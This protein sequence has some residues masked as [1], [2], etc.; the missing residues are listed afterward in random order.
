M[1]PACRLPDRESLRNDDDQTRR[2]VICDEA[3]E[4]IRHRLAIMTRT[5]PSL[6]AS[7]STWSSVSLVARWVRF[8]SMD[9]V[10]PS[11]IRSLAE[12]ANNRHQGANPVGRLLDLLSYRY[13]FVDIL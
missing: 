8:C 4:V 11:A 10:W 1:E 9:S 5:R 6:A 3:L 2:R 13:C 12:R 7:L